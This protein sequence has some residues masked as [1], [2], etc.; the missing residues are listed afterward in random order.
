[1]KSCKVW[2]IQN[3]FTNKYI[4]QNHLIPGFV[5]HNTYRYKNFIYFLLLITTYNTFYQN[6]FSFQ[7]NFIVVK[8]I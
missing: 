7:K 2:N 1:M 4:T 3:I 8:K 6:S 5:T